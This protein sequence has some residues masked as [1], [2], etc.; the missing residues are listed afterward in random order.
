MRTASGSGHAPASLSITPWNSRSWELASARD[1]EET[2][3]FLSAHAGGRH[4]A[5]SALPLGGVESCFLAA[6]SDRGLPPCWS[7]VPGDAGRV[8]EGAEL[9]SQVV[10]E[11]LLRE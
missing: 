3:D 4:D 11:Q 5:R 10:S 7:G 1:G 2:A 8:P 6:T 9:V